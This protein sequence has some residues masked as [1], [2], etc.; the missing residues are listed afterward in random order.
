[1]TKNGIEYNLKIS[2]YE[3]KINDYT[4]KFSSKFYKEKYNELLNE[5]AIKNNLSLS[6]RYKV[7]FEFSELWAILL[8]REIEKRGFYILKNNEVIT[9]LDDI[10]INLQL[11]KIKK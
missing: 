7:K 5:T 6:K 9:C 11:N 3:I 1:M 2:P 4:F 8:Y 10:I